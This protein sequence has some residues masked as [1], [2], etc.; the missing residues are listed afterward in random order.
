MLYCHFNKIIKE[1]G[2]S[3]QPP[4]FNQKHVR[5]VFHTAH[6]ILIGFRIKKK[7]HKSNLHYAAILMMTSQILKSVGFIK[8]QKSLYLKNETFFLKIK[9][10]TNGT[11]SATL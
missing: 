7:K 6:F 5:N 8:T 9:K 3:F 10:F 11:S 1:P 2:P 4:A